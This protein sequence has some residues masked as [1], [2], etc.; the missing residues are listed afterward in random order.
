MNLL[1]TGTK[2]RSTDKLT[3]YCTG[4][5]FRLVLRFIM[6]DFPHRC[7]IVALYCFT[8]FTNYRTFKEP[9]LERMLSHDVRGT[10]LLAKEG[11]NGTI[12]GSRGGIDRIIAWIKQDDLFKDIE[13]KESYSASNP[14]YRSK[15]KVKKEIVTMGV[16]G[17]DPAHS[18][19]TY[20]D[21]EKWN[22][23]I[24]DPEVLLLDTRNE[25]EIEIGTFQNAIN[26]KTSS[27][28]EFPEYVEKNLDPSKHKKIAMFCTGGIRC[29]KSTAFLKQKGFKD[30][31]HLKGGILKYLENV[32]EEESKWKGEC[33]VF[34]NRVAV[35]HKLERGS[36]DQC[37]A[38][39]MPI[40][41]GDKEKKEYV[42]GVSCHFCWGKHSKEQ[43]DR[44]S[45]REKQM[46][47]AGKR[48]EPHIGQ[49][50]Q[51]TIKRR[52]LEKVSSKEM[53][54]SANKRKSQ[55]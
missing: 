1:S 25:Y 7:V 39:R 4:F 8:K 6:N 14:F 51:A 37:H 43:I 46:R 28:R 3:F 55:Q 15:V 44:F 32:A 33:F 13:V 34:D 24:N 26:P 21:P 45:E 10:L 38:C 18:A 20:V 31:Y 2:A 41:E 50:M 40:T 9:L 22:S 54:R 49:P 16:D 52:K 36:Y 35:N 29:E 19:G 11:I 17:I 23:L 42:K 5:T 27:F 53:Q 48:G 47:L 30:V 12:A